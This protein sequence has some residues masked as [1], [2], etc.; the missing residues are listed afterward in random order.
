M[1]EG[2]TIGKKNTP[3]PSCYTH[4]ERHAG[5]YMD[6]IFH[7][8]ASDKSF[9]QQKCLVIPL[10]KRWKGVAPSKAAIPALGGEVALPAAVLFLYTPSSQLT[11]ILTRFQNTSSD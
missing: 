4:D 6:E 2:G 7:Y 5:G 3:R 10:Y 11:C 9:C 1:A 8:P